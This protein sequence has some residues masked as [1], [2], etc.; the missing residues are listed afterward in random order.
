MTT[1]SPSL[2]DPQIE[3]VLVQTVPWDARQKGGSLLQDCLHNLWEKAVNIGFN[4]GEKNLAWV[5]E[6]GF[7]EGKMAGF[8]ESVKSEQSKT[9]LKSAK[10]AEHHERA[11][12]AEQAW[13]YNVG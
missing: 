3:H 2:Q 12:E 6:E 13:G 10:A 5:K 7:C 11:L 8:T 1:P 4:Y 9:A